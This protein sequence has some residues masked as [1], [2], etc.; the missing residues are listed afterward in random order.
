MIEIYIIQVETPT[1]AGFK[2]GGVI[3]GTASFYYVSKKRL[4]KNTDVKKIIINKTI[5]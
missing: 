5:Y 4:S 2:L 3:L 1:G